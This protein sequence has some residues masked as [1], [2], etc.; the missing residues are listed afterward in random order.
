MK[1]KHIAHA[2][3]FKAAYDEVFDEPYERRQADYIQLARWQKTHTDV[4]PGQFAAFAKEQWNRGKFTPKASL[5]IR[6]LCANW[7]QM[8]AWK[9]ASEPRS[10]NIN[11]EIEAVRERDRRGGR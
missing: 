1:A 9:K 5:T 11:A 2:A 10:R 7:G 3:A 6:G 8:R 4:T